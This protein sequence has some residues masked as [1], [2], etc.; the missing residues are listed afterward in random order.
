MTTESKPLEEDLLDVYDGAV[1]N[2]EGF[3][4]TLAEKTAEFAKLTSRY[5][6]AKHLRWKICW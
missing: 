2:L 4:Q 6:D 3:T 5:S 1:L